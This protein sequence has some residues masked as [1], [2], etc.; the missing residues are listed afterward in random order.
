V[1]LT[2]SQAA[3]QLT[4]RDF[5]VG[6]VLEDVETGLGMVGMRERMGYIGGSV[7]WKTQPGHG[8]Q[9]IATVPLKGT[10]SQKATPPEAS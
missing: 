4:I 2:C 5:G 1:T 7:E 10:A 9:V 3:I 6:F 8:T